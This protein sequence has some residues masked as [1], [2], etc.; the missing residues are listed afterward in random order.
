[1]YPKSM[2]YRLQGTQMLDLFFTESARCYAPL[3]E[4]Y[5]GAKCIGPLA[6]FDVSDSWVEHPYRDGVVLM[7]DAAVTTDPTFGQGLSLALRGSRILRDEL[8]KDSDWAAGANRYAEQQGRYS[9]ACVT[10][11][12]WMRTLFQDPS[13]ESTRLRERAMPL[14]AQDPT[15]VP[16][17]I[18]SGPELPIND[19]VRARFF[20]EC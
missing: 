10:V 17:H 2:P 19:E 6:S 8:S 4:Y 15:R 3:A 1:M 7:G 5:A 16:D 13:P 14:I 20:G 9:R 18:F 11:E 12:G